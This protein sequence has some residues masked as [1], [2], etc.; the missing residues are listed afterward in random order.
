[1]TGQCKECGKATK[2]CYPNDGCFDMC[3]CDTNYDNYTDEGVR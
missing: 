2:E 1:M 3:E